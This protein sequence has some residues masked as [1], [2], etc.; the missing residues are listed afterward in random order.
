[1]GRLE[2]AKKSEESLRVLKFFCAYLIFIPVII[3][4]LPQQNFTQN[5]FYLCTHG[6]QYA[7]RRSLF[8]FGWKLSLADF[9][10]A[11]SQ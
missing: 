4:A 11:R 5:A 8:P 2:R 6:G 3:N 9:F 10:F 1:V 7:Q